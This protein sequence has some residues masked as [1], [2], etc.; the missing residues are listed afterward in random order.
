MVEWK[1]G[2]QEKYLE[3]RPMRR[4]GIDWSLEESGAVTLHLKN[5]GVFH[6]TAQ[7]FFHRPRISHVK[8]DTLG[9]L[10]WT[11][12]D[13]ERSI[14]QLGVTIHERFGEQAE[15][16]YE[17]VAYFMHTLEDCRLICWK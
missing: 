10:V 3:R 6:R 1:M 13:G 17:R 11:L 14:L 2:R 12:A 7:L 15:P 9:S 16:L 8:L 5:R 4:T